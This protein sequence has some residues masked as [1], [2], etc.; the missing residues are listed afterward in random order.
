MTVE[1]RMHAAGAAVAT[2]R[3]PT[4]LGVAPCRDE[5]GADDKIKAIERMVAAFRDKRSFLSPRT[6]D[7]EPRVIAGL[8]AANKKLARVS[9]ISVPEYRKTFHALPCAVRDEAFAG[10]RSGIEKGVVVPLERILHDGTGYL[11]AAA[12]RAM[13]PLIRV[14]A[15]RGDAWFLE[16]ASDIVPKAFT[17]AFRT[18]IGIFAMAQASDEVWRLNGVRPFIELWRSGHVPVGLLTDNSFLVITG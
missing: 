12:G 8:Q 10:L 17:D 5:R 15:D 2:T 1:Y 6:R 18:T 16:N 14:V 3:R 4:V 9:F 13:V 7:V 11:P